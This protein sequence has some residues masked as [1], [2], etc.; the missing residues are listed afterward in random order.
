M[1]WLNNGLHHQFS[2]V[3]TWCHADVR[4]G[5]LGVKENLWD[6]EKMLQFVAWCFN[7]HSVLN[8]VLSIYDPIFLCINAC[9]GPMCMCVHPHRPMLTMSILRAWV[10][11]NYAC[12]CLLG[13]TNNAVTLQSSKVLSVTAQWVQSRFVTSQHCSASFWRQANIKVSPD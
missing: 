1:L 2:E 6:I 10:S 12:V 13:A 11:R 4:L 9:L 3:R 5:T 7:L 8:Q